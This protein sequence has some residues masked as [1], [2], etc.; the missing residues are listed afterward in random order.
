[1]SS[2]AVAVACLNK[3]GSKMQN[4][5]L[6]GPQDSLQHYTF[7]QINALVCMRS[8]SPASIIVHLPAQNLF[9]SIPKLP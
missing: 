3:T 4:H 6:Q 5:K 7:A 8:M 2:R 9:Y 1:M